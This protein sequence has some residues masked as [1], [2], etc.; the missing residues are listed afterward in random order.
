MYR[1]L[2]QHLLF[3]RVFG[4]PDMFVQDTSA[5]ELWPEPKSVLIMD[6]ASFHRTAR[7]E[8]LCHEAACISTTVFTRPAE[9]KGFI[10]KH[11]QEFEDCP[12]QDFDMFLEWCLNMVGAK[13]GST[14]MHCTLKEHLACVQVIKID[15][16]RLSRFR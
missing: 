13:K 11:W 10:K 15:I 4:D 12:E 6:N 9:L 7:I 1:V 3:P 5:P 8:L 14:V 16:L 2:I